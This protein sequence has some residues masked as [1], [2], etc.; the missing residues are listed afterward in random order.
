MA[1][2]AIFSLGTKADTQ[3]QIM[4]CLGLSRRE[5]PMNLIQQCLQCLPYVQHQPDD[6]LQLTASSH[7]FIG[8]NLKLKHRVLK[9]LKLYHAER[10]STNFTDTK[11]AVQ[12]LSKY[13]EKDTQREIMGFIKEHNKDA[14]LVLL[15]Y[16]NFHG[17]LNDEFQTV[18]VADEN[19]YVDENTTIQ[20]PTLYS[21]GRFYL[22]RDELLSCWVLVQFYVGNI[23]AFFLLPDRGMMQRLTER[24]TIQHLENIRKFIDIKIYHLRFPKLNS[25]TISNLNTFL[26][27]LNITKFFEDEN[28]FWVSKIQEEPKT[29]PELLQ[30]AVLTM[31]ENGTEFE[32]NADTLVE[33]SYRDLTVRFN[34]PFL[35]IIGIWND[36]NVNI[37]LFMGKVV[38]PKNISSS[39]PMPQP[40]PPSHVPTP[41]K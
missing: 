35:V 26:K 8:N 18:S 20:V 38:N 32:A 34:R 31:S 5:L 27:K 21:W 13:A 33:Y 40:P 6:E 15:N 17:K 10:T 14:N 28:N 24:L 11:E 22:Q 1:V 7:L 41:P 29:F 37:P 4:K 36:F 25:I 39:I 9:N 16:M 2:V 23:T 19:F 12:Q 3:A 30:Q